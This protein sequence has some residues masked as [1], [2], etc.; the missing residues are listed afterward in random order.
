MKRTTQ[1]WQLTNKN[2]GKNVVESKT[3]ILLVKKPK[4]DRESKTDK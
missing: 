1:T 4:W 2:R 3:G